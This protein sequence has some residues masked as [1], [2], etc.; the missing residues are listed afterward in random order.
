MFLTALTAELVDENKDFLARTAAGI[1]LKNAL[2]SPKV[3][4]SALFLL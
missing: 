1:I 4:F 2:S 3:L